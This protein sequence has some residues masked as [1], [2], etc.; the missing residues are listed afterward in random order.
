MVYRKNPLSMDDLRR[1]AK[2]RFL[3][4]MKDAATALTVDEAQHLFEE[5]EIHQIELELQN[6]YLNQTRVQLE[7]ALSQSGVV[8]FLP[9]MT[10]NQ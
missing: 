4:R 1:R 8:P 3:G 2:E 10:E 6:E 7:T 5:L 9:V